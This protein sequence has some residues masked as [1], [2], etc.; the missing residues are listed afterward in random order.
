MKG[1]CIEIAMI[2]K[3]IYKLLPFILKNVHNLMKCS[4]ATQII[5]LASISYLVFINMVHRFCNF[6][7]QADFKRII[8]SS[9][10]LN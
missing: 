6:S 7:I 10:V 2:P 1:R 4:M 9:K 8:L 5:F 3:Y